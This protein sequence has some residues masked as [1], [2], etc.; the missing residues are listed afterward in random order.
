MVHLSGAAAWTAGGEDNAVCVDDISAWLRPQA[1]SVNAA[2]VS[3]AAHAFFPLRAP[4]N[5]AIIPSLS[6][7][8]VAPH[9]ISQEGRYS[10]GEFFSGALRLDARAVA[11]D[12]DEIIVRAGGRAERFTEPQPVPQAR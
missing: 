5:T 7:F 1:A 9:H 2:S 12:E 3:A 4:P 6:V 8:H 11:H 10:A